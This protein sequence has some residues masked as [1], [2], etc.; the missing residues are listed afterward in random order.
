VPD[1]PIGGRH[2][3]KD[4]HQTRYTEPYQPQTPVQVHPPG[5]NQRGLGDQQKDPGGKNRAVD[6]NKQ[7]GQRSA[8]HSGQIIGAR[9]PE[10]DGGQKEYSHTRTKKIVE[11]APTVSDYTGCHGFPETRRMSVAHVFP[12]E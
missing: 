12:E 6:M 10:K 9:E 7:V 8:E 11:A 3:A 2:Q 4:D 5:G 1:Q